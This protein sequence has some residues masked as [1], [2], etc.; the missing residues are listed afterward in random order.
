[1]FLP[2][3]IQSREIKTLLAGYHKELD[4]DE[5]FSEMQEIIGSRISSE[6]IESGLVN[7]TN[8]QE[9]WFPTD[10]KFHI[11]LSHAHKDETLIKQFAAYL[12]D[13]FHAKVFIDSCYWGFCDKLLRQLDNKICYYTDPDGK[14]MYNYHRRNFTTS[15]IHTMLANA[16]L[17]MMSDTETVIFVDSENSLKYNK[18]NEQDNTPSAWI[19]QEITYANCLEKR[20]PERWLGKIRFV[21][22]MREGG[23]LRMFCESQLPELPETKFDVDLSQF[24]NLT[25]TFLQGIAESNPEMMMN[26]LHLAYLNQNISSDGRRMITE[27][28]PHRFVFKRK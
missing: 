18:Y 23:Q 17:K 9:S 24:Y 14:G 4:F 21:N 7:G 16:L 28:V 26:R 5:D 6:M 3:R 13:R 8:L 15:L 1:M 10:Q 11:F 2:Y 22:S 27:N 19:Y 12:R 20:L 25:A